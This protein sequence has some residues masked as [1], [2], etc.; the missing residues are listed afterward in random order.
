MVKKLNTKNLYRIIF[1]VLMLMGIS[2]SMWATHLRAGEITLERVSCTELTFRITITVYT[3][4]GSPIKFGDGDLN[5]GDGSPVFKT[6]T[7]DNT[8]RPDLGPEIGTVSFTTTHTFPGPGKYLISYLEPN[9]NAG[10][11]NMTNSVDTRFYIETQI[12]IDPFLG[13]SNTPR[14]LVP[15]IDKGCTGAAFFHNP[16][17]YDPDGDSLS[18]ELTV[19]KRD[20]GVFVNGYLDPNAKTFY[21]RSGLDY[22][23]ANEDGNG[24]PTF[25]IDPVTGTLLW[26]APGAPGE[27][28]IAFLIKE[29]RKVQG[30]WLQI[31]FVVRDMQIII[32]DCLNKR[33]ELEVPPDICVEAGTVID[34]EIFG[35]DPDYDS[36]KIE[37]FSGVFT[38]NPSP[39]EFSPD[40][41]IYQRTAP[42]VKARL[43]FHW[44]TQCE[45]IQDQPYQVVFKIT[46]KSDNGPKLVE[47][48]TWNI[49]VVG[50][51]PK[52]ETA[53]VNLGERSAK[54]DWENYECKINAVTMQ[55]WRRVDQFA[56]TPP[57]CVTG[58]PESLGYTKI[59]EVPINTTTFKDTN[60]SRG[61]AVGAAYCYRLVAVFPQPGGGESYVS[62]EICLPPILADAPVITNVTVDITSTVNTN[63]STRNDGQVTVRWRPPFNADP[64]QFPPPYSY[65]VQRAE[66]FSGDLRLTQT[67]PGKRPDTVLVDTGLNTRDLIYNYRVTAYASNG[68]RVDVSPTA[69]TVR[70]ETSPQLKRIALAWNADVPWS[71]NTQDYP[72]HLIFR[73]PANATEGQLVLI[74]SVDVNQYQYNYVDSGQYNNQPLVETQLYCY[75]VM[76]RG[77]YG[78]PRIQEPLKNYSQIICAQPNDDEEPCQPALSIQAQSCE[79][80]LQTASCGANIFSNTLTWNRPSDPVC[81]ADIQ[82]YKIYKAS[83]TD[84]IFEPMDVPIV[85]DTFFIDSNLPSFAAC[86]KISA[87]DRAGNESE[88]SEP[89]CFDNCPYYELPN[90]FTP[91]GDNCNDLFSA[92]SDRVSVDEDGNSPCGAPIDLENLRKRCARFVQKVTFTVYNRWGREVYTYQSGGERTIYIDWDGHDNNGKELSGGVYYYSAEVIFDVVDPSKQKQIIKGWVQIVR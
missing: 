8:R 48:K 78:N 23:T 51:A 16:G 33:P 19:P 44:E 69:S 37:A 41:A 77:A 67:F 20:K 45:H 86:Y 30:V 15:P 29:W 7:I 28:S 35:F 57:V 85:R 9:R 60:N 68:T 22:N 80:Y 36:V 84:G 31:G 90:V 65:E 42:G 27:Y 58:M 54:L 43:A 61:L 1:T 81:A 13:C 14:L 75:R 26:D 87:V 64:G 62:Q 70:L 82:G 83:T 50:P 3:D 74:D 18:Y 56:F 66:G 17:A 46:D 71:N 72:R 40:P 24:P 88:L 39:A 32:E 4:T 38:I 53:V 21:D 91:N 12:I 34:Q 89:Y 11:L 63:G 52:W 92:F 55:V 6:P 76:T 49:R 2:H 25:S 5:F 73:G 59:A 79:E 10:I 47:F